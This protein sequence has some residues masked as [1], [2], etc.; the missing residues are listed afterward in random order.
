MNRIN[1]AAFLGIL[2]LSLAGCAGHKSAENPAYYYANAGTEA[3]YPGGGGATSQSQWP[4]TVVQGTT[5]NVVYEPQVDSW[6][7][8]QLLGRDAVAV[9]AAG[10]RQ[11]VFGVVNIQATTLV[12]KTKRTVTLESVK[13]L[14]GSFPSA[15]QESQQYVGPLQQ[16]FPKELQ[17]L[18]LD[19]L[20]ASLVVAPQQLQGSSQPL[21]NAPPKIIFST[22]PAILVYI[23]GPPVYRP[24]EHTGLQ[25]VIN[26]RLLILKDNNGRLYVHVLNGY[27]TAPKLEGPWAVAD[28]APP[29]AAQ[30]EQ[31]AQIGPIPA[32]LLESEG[33]SQTNAAPALSAATA[34]AVYVATSPTELVLFEGAPNF[35]PI[36]GTHLL[37]VANTT[38]NVFKL[39]TDQKNYLLISG[40]WFRAPSL[41]GPWQYVPANQL[42]AD[43]AN[44][45]DDSPKENVKASVPGTQQAAEALLANSIPESS[46]VA[47]TTQMQDPHIDG[48]LRLGA[49]AGTPLHY[50]VNS[51]TPIIEVDEHSWY[52][53]QSGVWFAAASVNG[54]W[55][56]ASSVP[57][58]IYSIPP[59][60]PLHYLTYVQVYGS[61]PDLVYE[62][63]TPGYLGTEVEDGVVVY[64][65][66]Y[67]YPPWIGD[68]W[69]GWPVTWGFG[70]GPCW[71]PW[72]DWCF[73]FGFGW[74]IGFGPVG[75]W[76]CYPLGPWW[77]GYRHFGDRGGLVAGRRGD[78]FTTAGNLY[79][80]SASR[81]GFGARPGLDPAARFSSYGRAYNSRTGAPAAGQRAGAPGFSGSFDR[82]R[83]GNFGHEAFAAR[84][85]YPNGSG[86]VGSW[87]GTAAVAPRYASRSSFGGFSGP[88]K[89]GSF[90]APHSYGGGASGGYFRGGGYAGYGGYSRGY[91]GGYSRGGGGWGG[92][93]GGGGGGGHGGGGGGGGGHG[94]GGR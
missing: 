21:N 58:V 27:M 67:Y 35:V 42:A 19:R 66:G 24:V 64:G 39:L 33:A 84:G 89:A 8:H 82:N 34:P 43:F 51:G 68:Y 18:S 81:G 59:S 74:G 15:P 61:S 53:C 28:T 13:V 77:G 73:G 55:T 75:F 44:I 72:D 36:P 14:G 32:D 29:G 85:Q 78:R 88:H 10:Q 2:A 46:S 70:W 87:R 26:S 54:P 60:S 62:G 12:N 22:R 4:R 83:A 71:T 23:D 49:I 37:Y 25:R 1:R 30:A 65:T 40:R 80:R 90:A 31:E 69:Y 48:A 92:H 16:S 41:D 47:R 20:E 6:D 50:V 52:A 86:Q 76:G 63:Y 17:G 91:G 9:S 45:P 57:A 5:T 3:S 11:P 94:G 56:V 7:G 79:A 93:G 38:G